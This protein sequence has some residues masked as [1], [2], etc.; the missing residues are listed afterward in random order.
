MEILKLGKVTSSTQFICWCD[1]RNVCLL[2]GFWPS[3]NKF[4]EK[5]FENKGET[6]MS[7]IEKDPDRF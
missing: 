4:V 2:Y 6:A 5:S 7:V 1:W 3:M